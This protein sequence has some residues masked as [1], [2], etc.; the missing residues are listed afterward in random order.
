MTRFN[1][2]LTVANLTVLLGMTLFLVD[3]LDRPIYAG[4]GVGSGSADGYLAVTTINRGGSESLYLIDT[5]QKSMSVYEAD[6]GQIRLVA[7]RSF[8]YDGEIFE[9]HD[10][11]D[12]EFRAS[13][14]RKRIQER[15]AGSDHPVK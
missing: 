1:R 13:A 3:S 12:P 7:V 14:L 15:E 9:Y 10:G 11:S 8:R 6:R 5:E 2:I 4:E